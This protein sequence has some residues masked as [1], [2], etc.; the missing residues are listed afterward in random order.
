MIVLRKLNKLADVKYL[1]QYVHVLSC[2]RLFAIPWAV[3]HIDSLL[4]GSNLWFLHQQADFLL[5]CHL[6]SPLV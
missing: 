6:G 2:V 5:L 3:A 1:V 4:P